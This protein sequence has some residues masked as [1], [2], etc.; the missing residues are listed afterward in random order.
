[1]RLFYLITST[2]VFALLAASAFAHDYKKGSLFIDHPWSRANP[3]GASVAAGY[4][5]IENRGDTADRLLSASSE[6]AGRAEFHVMAVQDRVM[7]MRPLVNG[8]AIAPGKNIKLQSG[9]IHIMFIDLKRPLV[10]G[11]RF[12]GT[13]TFEKAGPVEVEFAVE[14]MGG[15]GGHHKH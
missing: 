4:L 6:I 10:E 13:L 7:K 1:M 11:E 3:R 15:G 14:A 12:T 8:L 9:G 2:T 5:V